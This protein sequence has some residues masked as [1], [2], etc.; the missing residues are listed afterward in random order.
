MTL[1][2]DQPDLFNVPSPSVIEPDPTY[3]MVMTNFSNLDEQLEQASSTA[4]AIVRKHWPQAEKEQYPF[5]TGILVMALLGIAAFVMRDF[6]FFP[7]RLGLVLPIIML[8]GLLV[9]VGFYLR[10]LS[11]RFDRQ[12][13][14]ISHDG[15]MFRF[16]RDAAIVLG[17]PVDLGQPNQNF[18]THIE[19]GFDETVAA[20]D[21]W[22]NNSVRHGEPDT[23]PT[24]GP[25]PR[26]G[27]VVPKLPA[28]NLPG[29]ARHRVYEAEYRGKI[30]RAMSIR[31][32]RV[33]A[34]C[35]VEI[36]FP[37]RT[38]SAETRE[39]LADSV[40]GRIQDRLIASK[41]LGDI[42]EAAGVDPIPIPTVEDF[43]QYLGA[44]PSRAV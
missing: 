16:M 18:S 31:I 38:A 28:D 30:V 44:V 20:V 17:F 11:G 10:G 21:R 6:G 12:W 43:Q 14:L 36:G 29:T 37:V 8:I 7:T 34:G 33:D 41:V 42:R 4:A 1:P 26:S 15:R 2:I 35:D 22:V 9:V 19:L 39:R 5:W 23:A 27:L 32:N 40:A 25:E 13:N 3:H 24:P